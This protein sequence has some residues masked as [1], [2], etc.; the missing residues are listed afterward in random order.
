MSDSLPPIPQ[1]SPDGQWWWDGVR[2]V[3]RSNLPPSSAPV[4]TPTPVQPVAARER[5]RRRGLGSSLATLVIVGIAAAV[6]WAY[7]NPSPLNPPSTTDFPTEAAVNSWDGGVD[8]I[9]AIQHH[10]LILHS[11]CA[12]GTGF[13]I[14]SDLVLT[15]THVV[16][17]QNSGVTVVGSQGNVSAGITEQDP[18]YDVTELTTS[19]TTTNSH[20]FKLFN[21]RPARGQTLWELCAVGVGG[22]Q[23]VYEVTVVNPSAPLEETDTS[24]TVEY[25]VPDAINLNGGNHD[26]CSGAPL[27]DGADHVVGMIVAGDESTS[28][29]AIS[30]V[31]IRVW[32][33]M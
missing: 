26:G 2:W 32:L 14:A 5:R 23:A 13:H 28:V 11:P 6:A 15:A 25:N 1:W 4:R 8:E 9:Q 29:A 10:Y 3:H 24:G 33:G 30:S 20:V 17:C 21:G 16:T 7:L 12:E 27:V 22:P 19:S 31:D 18:S